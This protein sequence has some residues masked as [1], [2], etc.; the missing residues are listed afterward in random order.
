MI[1][2]HWIW[3]RGFELVTRKVELIA[4]EI[5]LMDLNSLLVDLKWHFWTPTRAF[6]LSARN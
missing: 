1:M 6:K 3:T 2:D 5:E 4:R